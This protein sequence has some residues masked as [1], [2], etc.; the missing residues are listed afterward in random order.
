MT[1]Y[2]GNNQNENEIKH[3]YEAKRNVKVITDI[4]IVEPPT[5]CL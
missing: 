5:Q 1:I 2:S 4:E 3:R